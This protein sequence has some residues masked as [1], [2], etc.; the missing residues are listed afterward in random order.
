MRSQVKK[1]VPLK[2]GEGK[3]KNGAIMGI[4][5]HRS[6]LA[7]CILN[8]NSFLYEQNHSN[9]KAGL[10]AILKL[11]K[12]FDVQDVAMEATSTYHLK[13][14][15][16]LI[17]HSI[18]VLLACAKQTADTQGRKT[19]KLDAQRIAVAHRDGRLKPSVI[20]PKEFTHL[21][22][23]TRKLVML[24][25]DQTK[26]KQRIQQLFQLYD[27]HLTSIHSN[28]LKTN[29]SLNL[30]LA[31]LEITGK[32]NNKNIK[33]LVQEHYPKKKLEKA[34]K[35]QISS[36]QD[37]IEHLLNQLSLVEKINLQTEL[38]QIR[39]FDKL[40]EQYRLIYRIFSQE[41]PQF[42]NDMELLL[43][44]PGVGPDTAAIVLAEVVDIKLFSKPEKL[45][46]WSGLAPRV[47]QSGHR[48]KKTEKFTRVETNI[49][50][51]L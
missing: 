30:L 41:H 3:R 31:C 8:E 10:E 42:K 27:C 23:S 21:R 29:W 19:D 43:S 45:V 50:E 32:S 4:D 16:A 35:S 28:F 15:F 11:I 18:P 51:E 47:L 25:Q 46:K 17:D 39:M 1:A 37:E 24:I 40:I 22:R 48:K 44:I 7:I 36:L 6:I 2:D 20:S 5:V 49:S 33:E 38:Y 34:T 12:R 14:C 9:D 13:V 26:S